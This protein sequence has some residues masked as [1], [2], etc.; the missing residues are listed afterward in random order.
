MPSMD[1]VQLPN[2]SAFDCEASYYATAF[3]ELTN[4]KPIVERLQADDA[5][6]GDRLAADAER[7]RWL[8]QYGGSIYNE[9]F[10]DD[11]EYT[12]ESGAAMLDAAIDAAPAQGEMK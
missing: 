1:R 2:K 6:R 12:L 11:V 3:H 10:N 8:R 5:A 4:A 7:Y 9:V